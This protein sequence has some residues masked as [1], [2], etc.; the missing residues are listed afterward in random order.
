MKKLVLPLSL[1]LVVILALIDYFT[2][3]EIAFSIFYLIPILVVVWFDKFWNAI[4]T[5]ILSSIAWLVADVASGQ[6]YSHPLIPIWNMMIRLGFFI[7]IV[8]LTS[9]VKKDLE[10]EKRLSRLD[11][12]T[13]LNNT[14]FFMER[15]EIE[16]NRALRFK[17]PFTV[18][19]FDIDNFKQLNDT[20]GHSAGDFLLRDLGRIIRENVRAYDIAARLG[21]DEFIIFLPETDNQQAQEA[22]N[23]IKSS[24]EKVLRA[25]LNS[26][27]LSIGVVTVT[28]P[29]Y[30]IE[31]IIKIADDL[32]YSV[33]KSSKNSIEYRMLD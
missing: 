33:K 23:K 13:G 17:R 11:M 26:L 28:N 18:A 24:I 19:Y 1:I 8:V 30:P 4:I 6:H 14:M 29:A 27:T 10:L 2:G 5:S 3:Y 25:H 22:T 31:G 12:L 9:R 16:K 15:A 32:M 21:G 7:I 20:F